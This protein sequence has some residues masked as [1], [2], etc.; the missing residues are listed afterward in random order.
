MVDG[1]TVKDTAEWSL[2]RLTWRV[3]NSGSVVA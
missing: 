2:N 1:F 3:L